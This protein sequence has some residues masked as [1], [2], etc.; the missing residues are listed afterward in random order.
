MI[1]FLFFLLSISA[2]SEDLFFYLGEKKQLPLPEDSV[3]HFG[4]QRILSVRE[5]RGRLILRGKA[6]GHTWLTLGSKSYRIFIL[7]RS[8]KQKALLVSELLRKMWGLQWTLGSEMEVHGTLNS[9]E[10]WITLSELSKSHS[11]SYS[12]KAQPGEDLKPD[13]IDFFKE[14][15]NDQKPAEIR[16]AALPNVSV[17]QGS[18]LQFYQN[19]L[20][21]FGLKP[22]EDS[23]WL[24]TKPFIKIEVAVLEVSRTSSLGLGAAPRL[25]DGESFNVS[26]LLKFIDLLKIQ[27][28]GKIIQHSS[29]LVQ[30]GEDFKIHSG[31]QIPFSQ[32]NFQTHQES[33]Q[34]KQYGL[35]LDITPLLDPY[36]NVLLKINAI[37]SEPE[38]ILSDNGVPP[39]KNQTIKTVFQLKSGQIVKI[40]QR[41]KK[42]Q[43]IGSQGGFLSNIPFVNSLSQARH[44]FQS[45]QIIL[46]RPEIFN[47]ESG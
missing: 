3:A 38:A 45:L 8:D 17:P 29:L 10:D 23:K 6:R 27:G 40:L 21:P 25:L 20:K 5:Q 35:T 16:W 46:I 42:G 9:L 24:L 13:V 32:Y 44:N 28:K 47:R 12:F 33:T 22:V 19:I 31:G 11:I 14:L 43:R 41:E 15:F 2:F 7:S 4:D 30:S 1:C 36:E 26:S 18:N 34:W 37:F 39:I